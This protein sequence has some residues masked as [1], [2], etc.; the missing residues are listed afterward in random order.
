MGH[1]V[2]TRAAADALVVFA[3]QVRASVPTSPAR[4][5]KNPWPAATV[6][7]FHSTQSVLA[8]YGVS[9]KVLAQLEPVKRVSHSAN[10]ECSS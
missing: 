8:Q 4:Q 7:E 3:T 1:S 9:S 2:L 6:V 5:Q 10:V